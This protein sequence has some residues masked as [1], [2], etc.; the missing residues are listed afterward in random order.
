MF[1]FP[2]RGT[3][4]RILQSYFPTT[5]SVRCWFQAILLRI[6]P[7]MED[8]RRTLKQDPECGNVIY[9]WLQ[10]TPCTLLANTSPFYT[11]ILVL[12]RR[13]TC[14][15]HFRK[16]ELQDLSLHEPVGAGAW[17]DFGPTCKSIRSVFQRQDW[18]P[19]SLFLEAFSSCSVG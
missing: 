6:K 1:T 9:K 2:N 18:Q 3:G 15:L 14:A 11:S 5:R 12:R 7:P 13:A 16:F 4:L 10:A 17:G 19:R 8:L